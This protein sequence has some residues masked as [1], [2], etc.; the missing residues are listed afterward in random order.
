MA[1]L[2][3]VAPDARVLFVGLGGGAMPRYVRWRFPAMRTEAVELEYGIV[4][5]A[6]SWFGFPPDSVIPV[7]V[8]DGRAFIE[9]APAE[10]WDLVVLDAFSGGEVPRALTTM[11]FL[12]AVRRTLA[13]GGVVVS[14]LHT[15]SPEYDQMVA[16]YGGVFPFVALL[17]VPRRRQV[18]LLASQGTDLSRDV[19]LERVRQMA[20]G[21]DL[22]FDLQTLVARGYRVPPA[23]AAPVLRDVTPDRQ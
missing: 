6:R 19:V 16:T 21:R 15:S 10:S 7:H 23:G 22:G 1:A 12:Q 14:N 3:M 20:V 9:S 4:V 13:P 17:S 5:A 8:G 18:V 11:E 2:A